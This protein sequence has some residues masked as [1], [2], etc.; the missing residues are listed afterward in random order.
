M[1][2]SFSTGKAASGRGDIGA[3]GDGR[4]TISLV[5]LTLSPLHRPLRLTW[6][7]RPRLGG[8]VTYAAPK[9]VIRETLNVPGLLQ[10]QTQLILAQISRI[11]NYKAHSHTRPSTAIALDF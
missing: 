6:S 10:L 1:V 3:N 11:I 2:R 9:L 7:A 8:G 4:N 5:E